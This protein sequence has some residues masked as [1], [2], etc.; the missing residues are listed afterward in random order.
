MP[1]KTHTEWA[2]TL[3]GDG[4]STQIELSHCRD[5]DIADP[6]LQKFQAEGNFKK[7]SLNYLYQEIIY[8]GKLQ[9]TMYFRNILYICL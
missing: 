2:C 7:F 6:L 3:T 5:Y 8:M 4:I 9:G 1:R